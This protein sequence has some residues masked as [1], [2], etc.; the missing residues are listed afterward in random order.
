MK[1]E[2]LGRKSFMKL[3]MKMN[4]LS[5]VFRVGYLPSVK[6]KLIVRLWLYILE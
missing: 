1:G 2:C 6:Q 4:N 3:G 5:S